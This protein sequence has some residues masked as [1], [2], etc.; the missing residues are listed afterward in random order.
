M[1]GFGKA[2]FGFDGPFTK[3]FKLKI[4]DN[5]YR[6]IPPIKS[7]IERGV[8]A[9]YHAVHYGYA[10][11]DRRD[12]TKTKQR[13]FECV[14]VK[15][16]RSGMVQ[17]ECAACNFTNKWVERKN[18]VINEGKVAGKTKE[19]I[20]AE[21]EPINA[22]L[23]QYNTDKKFYLNVMN[24]AGEFGVLLLSYTTKRKKLD[25]RIEELRKSEPGLDVT[26]PNEG[27][28]L[29]FHREGAMLEAEDSVDPVWQ[30]IE[31]PGTKERARVIKRAPLSEAQCKSA[32]EC[33]DLN[34]ITTRISAEQ[35]KML[36]DSNHE[37]DEIDRIFALSSPRSE[38]SPVQ[39]AASQATLD[40][41]MAYEKAAPAP[42]P[43]AP[44][45]DEE[46]AAL[47][48]LAAIRAKKAAVGAEPQKKTAADFVDAIFAEKKTGFS[49]ES[50]TVGVPAGVDP[51]KMSNADFVK[52]FKPPGA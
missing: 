6:I 39:R 26:D 52:M 14:E 29:N 34:E 38:E 37:P 9:V 35:V 33:P 36:V 44:V 49:A 19:Q 45:D 16:F 47:A 7:C 13:P 32:L 15:D 21:L 18:S 17:V 8:W 1:D 11:Q 22:Q 46:A 4:G 41:A 43:S 5:I 28:W 42:A 2:K 40:V 27:I 30:M 12:P 50:A 31:I 20:N 48:A 24:E 25:P 10:G 23:K 3:Y 51:L